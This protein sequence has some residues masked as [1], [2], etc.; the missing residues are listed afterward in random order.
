MELD[1][2]RM[3]KGLQKIVICWEDEVGYCFKP[4]QDAD[5]GCVRGCVGQINDALR[6]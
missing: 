3:E 2:G 4:K 1:D 6:Q 5:E